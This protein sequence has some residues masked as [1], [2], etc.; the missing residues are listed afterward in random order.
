MKFGEVLPIVGEFLPFRFSERFHR[1]TTMRKYTPF[2]A[3]DW[4]WIAKSDTPGKCMLFLVC[5]EPVKVSDYKQLKTQHD[6]HKLHQP[7]DLAHREK[8]TALM[9][10][11]DAVTTFIAEQPSEL[12]AKLAQQLDEAGTRNREVDVDTI[13]NQVKA[14]AA[15]IARA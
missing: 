5:L 6:L 14:S 8:I 12:V 3:A 7:I 2:V 1:D 15:V 13:I 11:N 9:D 10:N 4:P